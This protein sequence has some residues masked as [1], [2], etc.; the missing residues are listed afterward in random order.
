V[1]GEAEY[2]QAYGMPAPFVHSHCHDA[3]NLQGPQP[4]PDEVQA[5]SAL[6]GS[7][8]CAAAL[9][10]LDIPPA[11]VALPVDAASAPDGLTLSPLS[12]PPQR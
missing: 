12:P 11:A 9:L 1:P 2:V 3:I 5:A 4:S 8:N 10:T 7:I 6:A